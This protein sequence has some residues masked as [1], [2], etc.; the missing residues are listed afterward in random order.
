MKSTIRGFVFFSTSVVCCLYC[1]SNWHIHHHQQQL[2]KAGDGHSI[3][4]VT[5][6]QW[7]TSLHCLTL[8]WL[9][10]LW[11]QSSHLF[12]GNS[13][14]ILRQPAG[15]RGTSRGIC[16][17]FKCLMSRNIICVADDGLCVQWEGRTSKWQNIHIFIC[18]HLY[19]SRS[20]VAIRHL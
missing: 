4:T 12:I 9:E 19:M 5:W 20:V 11:S 10:S 6:S 2:C 18:W 1:S 3:A 13:R 15:S 7:I 16:L 8:R 17:T 14:L